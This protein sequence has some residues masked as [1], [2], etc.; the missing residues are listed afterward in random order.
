M[1]VFEYVIKIN[2]VN[3]NLNKTIKRKELK[4]E[5]AQ[6]IKKDLKVF[7]LKF[8]QQELRH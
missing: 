6:I 2:Q 8:H 4:Q 3:S 5:T 1:K 7:D